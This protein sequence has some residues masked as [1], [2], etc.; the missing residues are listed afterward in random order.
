M[1]VSRKMIQGKSGF[2][3]TVIVRKEDGEFVCWVGDCSRGK[4]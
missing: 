3:S 1:I 4:C 2:N